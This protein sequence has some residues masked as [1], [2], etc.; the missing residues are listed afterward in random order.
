MKSKARKA[1]R[2]KIPAP[3]T[4]LEYLTHKKLAIPAACGGKGI[5]GLCRVRITGKKMPVHPAETRRISP[6]MI[7]NGYRLACRQ[8]WTRG[9]RILVP[10]TTRHPAKTGSNL[11]L[12]VD[13]GTTVI[14]A[15]A[16]DLKTGEI[17]ARKS[18]FNPQNN[19][20][21]DILTRVTA[22]LNGKQDEL[23][24]MLD[25]GLDEAR[26]NLGLDDKAPTVVVGNPVMLS[27]Y[28]N[29]PLKGYARHPF[30]GGLRFPSISRFKNR[31]IFPIVGGFVGGDTLA[32]IYA[33]G[34]APSR[35]FRRLYIDLGT[36]GEVAVMDRNRIWATSTAAGPAFEGAGISC[37]SLAVPG[38]IDRVW[39]DEKFRF[40]TIRDK[41][42]VGICAS[43]LIDLLAAALD[44]GYLEESGRLIRPIRIADLS[45]T[46]E[47]VRTLQLA[48]AA[49]HAGIRILL[50]KTG[51]YSSQ[52]DETV[53]TGEFGRHLNE[54]SLIRI[55]LIPTGI[56]KL[57]RIADLPLEGAIRSLLDR[58][59]TRQVARLKKI[60]RHVDLARQTDFQNKFVAALR[61]APWN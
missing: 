22:A 3:K 33:L 56:K 23:K 44:S 30:D 49:L 31:R 48:V 27:F 34:P 17:K 60:S 37:G 20:G 40:H 5:C 32:G 15:A 25:R 11:G 24:T 45:V 61:L 6:V 2:G 51:L 7:K 16:V 36:N 53:I 58:N 21:G 41:T 29:R 42:A 14:K 43:G 10:K 54:T 35:A 13:I 57:S 1:D 19:L 59:S 46:Q 18:V 50:D 55:G 28:L 52:I 9:I 12:A 26:I 4:V 47:D 8:D 39:F 38:A